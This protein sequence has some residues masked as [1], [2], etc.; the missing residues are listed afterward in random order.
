MHG[1]AVVGGTAPHDGAAAISCRSPFASARLPKLFHL[2]LLQEPS[3]KSASDS[4]T[5]GP[6]ASS[7]PGACDSRASATPASREHCFSASASL[8]CSSTACAL[9]EQLLERVPASMQCH[10]QADARTRPNSGLRSRPR[11]ERSSAR[12][13]RP[14]CARSTAAVVAAKCSITSPDPTPWF[15]S[16]CLAAEK[17]RWV[18]SVVNV[19]EATMNRV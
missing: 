19:L 10:R 9:R 7:P 6:P 3:A 1:G 4:C 12:Q 15:S 16:H 18:S 13:C 8:K 17:F 5:A 2:K 14:S 11:T